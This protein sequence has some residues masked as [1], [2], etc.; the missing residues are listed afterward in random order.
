[1]AKIMVV[2]DSAVDRRLAG[3]LLQRRLGATDSED[4]SGL[5][6]VYA[7]NGVEALSVLEREHPDLILTDLQMPEMNG[8]ELVQAVRSKHP[9]LPIILMTAHGSEEIA[10]QALES[11]AASYVPK[12]QLLHN[13]LDTVQDVL[14]LAGSRRQEERLLED[15]WIQTESHFRLPNNLD[16]VPTLVGYLQDNLAR[17][18][19]WDDNDR[20]RVAVALREA[21]SN[22]IIHGNLE[23]QSELRDTDEKGYYALIE[24]RRQQEPYCHRY[25]QVM[26]EESRAELVYVI[27]DQGP[28]F[29]FTRIPDPTDPT[30]LDRV[31]GRGLFLIRTF[32]TEVHFNTPGNE[33][34]MIKRRDR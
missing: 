28:G 27:I 30:N 17:R 13:L 22:A 23:V 5:E 29:D 25:V 19:I 7:S 16:Y 2:D 33:I 1:M 32:M 24:L 6:V 14:L 12:R 10:I 11:G 31:S 3:N 15:C 18:K 9:G 21:L 20:I 8:L 26:A 34:T 4:Q